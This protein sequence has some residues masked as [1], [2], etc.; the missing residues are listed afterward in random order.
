VYLERYFLHWFCF[1]LA[2]KK[3]YLTN[4]GNGGFST[5][6]DTTL[7]AQKMEFISECTGDY[8]R[9]NGKDYHVCNSDQTKEFMNGDVVMASF[10]ASKECTNLDSSQL[11]CKMYHANEG[12]VNVIAIKLL[13]RPTTNPDFKVENVKMKVVVN[14][15]GYYLQ[16]NNEDYRVCNYD[17]LKDFKVGEWVIGS[18]SQL[19]E[20]IFNG[21]KVFCSMYHPNNGLVTAYNIQK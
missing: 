3:K 16:Y 13:Y 19:N 7:V 10:I 12:W 8:L 9:L 18:M 14:C 2:V 1:F 11:T 6:N 5:G 17:L 20:C 15:S 4:G 21:D